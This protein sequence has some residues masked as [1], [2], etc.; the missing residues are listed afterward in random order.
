MAA[1]DELKAQ[2]LEVQATID[3]LNVQRVRVIAQQQAL[4]ARINVYAERRTALNQAIRD[5]TDGWTPAP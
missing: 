1:I 5:L 3:S 2:R 4:L